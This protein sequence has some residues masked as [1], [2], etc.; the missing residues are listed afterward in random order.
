MAGQLIINY[1]VNFTMISRNQIIRVI[2][3]IKALVFLLA[4]THATSAITPLRTHPERGSRPIL[5]T[6]WSQMGTRSDVV[7]S[8]ARPTTRPD[9]MI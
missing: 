6:L 3:Q 8:K 7:V 9:I 5:S 1:N 2:L 4:A